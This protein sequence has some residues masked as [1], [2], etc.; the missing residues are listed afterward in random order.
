VKPEPLLEPLA[1]SV[2]AAGEIA[3]LVPRLNPIREAAERMQRYHSRIKH[4]RQA[5]QTIANDPANPAEVAQWALQYDDEA[6]K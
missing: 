1:D 6:Q 4:M 5:L 3:K 2:F